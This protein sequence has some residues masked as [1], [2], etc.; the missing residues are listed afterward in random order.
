[1]SKTAF[2]Y[3]NRTLLSLAVAAAVGLSPISFAQ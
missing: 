2:E 3:R 1:M